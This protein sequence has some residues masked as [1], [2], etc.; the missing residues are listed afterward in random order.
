MEICTI[1]KGKALQLSVDTESFSMKASSS[2]YHISSLVMSSLATNPLS[3]NAMLYFLQSLHG[4]KNMNILK[5]GMASYIPTLNQGW[6]STFDRNSTKRWRGMPFDTIL[7]LTDDAV[8]KRVFP[9]SSFKLVLASWVSPND[10][11]N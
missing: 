10:V 11:Q 3:K 6:Q 2:I 7:S 8:L 9:Y 5:L 4:I 1:K